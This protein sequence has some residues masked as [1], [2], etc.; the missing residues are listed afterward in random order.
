[1]KK[2]LC[3]V[4]ALVL[5]CSLGVSAF[6]VDSPS[7]D[8]TSADTT[9]ALPVIAEEEEDEDLEAGFAI[10]DAATDDVMTVIPADQVKMVPVDEADSLEDADKEAF[11]AE[12]EKVKE[13]KDKVVK[14]FFWLQI[15]EDYTVDAEHYL[16]FTF[17]CKGENVEVTVDGEPME[18]VAVEGEADT[19]FAK[20]TKLGAVAIC[21]DAE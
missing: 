5:V 17:K 14:Y 16:R 3:V 18:V 13:I 7:K 2:I 15:P 21:C 8:E 12:Y 9:A 4:L 6:A 1:M 10:C 19:Y 20:L 11:L